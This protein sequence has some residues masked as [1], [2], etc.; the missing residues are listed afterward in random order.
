[1]F[2]QEDKLLETRTSTLTANQED[3]ANEVRGMKQVGLRTET[4]HDYSAMLHRP[5]W[6][7]RTRGKVENSG[8]EGS[9][10]AF[11]GQVLPARDRLFTLAES[12]GELLSAKV[13]VGDVPRHLLF[14]TFRQFKAS[15]TKVVASTQDDGVVL[16]Q[17]TR[18]TVTM[19]TSVKLGLAGMRVTISNADIHHRAPTDDEIGVLASLQVNADE[20]EATVVHRKRLAKDLGTSRHTVPYV[21]VTPTSRQCLA[22]GLR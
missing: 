13:I 19:I 14:K 4:L 6:F 15:E 2:A 20:G 3:G 10:Y 16:S 7:C 1:M 5:L 22:T 11:D 9:S 8:H 12:L 21:N 18:Q 17:V